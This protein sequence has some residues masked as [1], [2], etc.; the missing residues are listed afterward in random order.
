MFLLKNCKIFPEMENNMLKRETLKNYIKNY[1]RIELETFFQKLL[2][3]GKIQYIEMF[4]QIT[5]KN[6]INSS[7]IL[8]YFK[9]CVLENNYELA[10]YIVSYLNYI[11]I[12]L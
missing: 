6:I 9:I 3:Y 10:W 1:N 11:F 5:N 8:N 12:V 2:F 4:L 7:T